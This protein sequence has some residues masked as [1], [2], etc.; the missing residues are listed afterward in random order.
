MEDAALERAPAIA[1]DRG[2]LSAIA[3]GA[4]WLAVSLLLPEP[5][6]YV[7][8]ALVTALIV[9][10]IG[11]ARWSWARA[12]ER[13]LDPTR[14]AFLA[15]VTFGASMTLLLMPARMLAESRTLDQGVACGECGR[16]Q[17]ASEA[18][19]FGCGAA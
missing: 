3:F 8:L 19:C 9:L 14:W 18:F 6:R 5:L 16:V 15:T 12:S 7:S 13:G 1:D 4:P 11:A 10:L 17:L 2:A